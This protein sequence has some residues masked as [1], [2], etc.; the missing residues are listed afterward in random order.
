MQWARIMASTIDLGQQMLE[1]GL[2]EEAAG[3]KIDTNV[4]TLTSEWSPLLS[5]SL[6]AVVGCSRLSRR[7]TALCVFGFG[8]G[9][10]NA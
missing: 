3:I 4:R 7:T 5:L 6:P 1:L 8:R 9:P 2:D 10:N